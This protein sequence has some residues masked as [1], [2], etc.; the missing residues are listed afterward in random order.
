[1]GGADLPFLRAARVKISEILS[2]LESIKKK[3]LEDTARYAGLLLAPA[4]SFGLC[5]RLFF[6]L[7][8]KKRAYYADLAHFWEF[9]VPSSNMG[10]FQ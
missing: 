4:E 5:H 3:K 10:N 7:L 9:L 8:A 2:E 6:A 1:M